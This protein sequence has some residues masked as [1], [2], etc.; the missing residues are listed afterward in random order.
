[1]DINNEDEVVEVSIVKLAVIC[2]AL[3]IAQKY[4]NVEDLKKDLEKSLDDEDS[5]YATIFT[6]ALFMAKEEICLL[7]KGKEELIKEIRGRDYVMN[8]IEHYSHLMGEDLR[9]KKGWSVKELDDKV[10]ELNNTN[11]KDKMKVLERMMKAKSYEK[12]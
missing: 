4:M 5:F 6:M 3:Y 9:A 7:F 2:D 10:D 1:M 8:L 11:D 12:N